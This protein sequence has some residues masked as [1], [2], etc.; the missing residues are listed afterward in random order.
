VIFDAHAHRVDEYCEENG[1]LEV[2]MVDDNF[3]ATPYGPQARTATT[4]Y[5]VSDHISDG[6]LNLE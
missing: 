4:T 6:Q 2:A 1:A 5:I 3:E